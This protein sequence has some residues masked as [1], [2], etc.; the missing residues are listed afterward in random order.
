MTGFASKWS[1]FPVIRDFFLCPALLTY[2]RQELI[3]F[4]VCPL[5]IGDISKKINRRHLTM[6]AADNNFI[7]KHE[8]NLRKLTDIGSTGPGCDLGLHDHS[9]HLHLTVR[10]LQADEVQAGR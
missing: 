10:Q 1:I 5:C 2:S 9:F 3:V 6:P 7:I 8:S 4:R